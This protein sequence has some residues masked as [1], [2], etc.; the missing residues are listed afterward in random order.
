MIGE[1]ALDEIEDEVKG[2]FYFKTKVDDN[3]ER[4]QTLDLK[5][6]E[7][8][9][10]IKTEKSWMKEARAILKSLNMES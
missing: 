1:S 5:K 6:K 2:N 8:I 9:N 7:I 4:K 10:V 3:P